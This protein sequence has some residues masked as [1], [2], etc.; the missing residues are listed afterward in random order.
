MFKKDGIIYESEEEYMLMKP[1]YKPEPKRLTA[2]ERVWRLIAVICLLVVLF[3]I[4]SAFSEYAQNLW[5]PQD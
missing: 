2:K 5:A 1:E 3:F 4:I